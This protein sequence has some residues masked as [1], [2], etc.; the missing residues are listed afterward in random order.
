M[1]QCNIC[2]NRE[3][4]LIHAPRPEFV[5]REGQEYLKPMEL[6]FK[7]K[8]SR[9]E[10]QQDCKGYKPIVRQGATILERLIMSG[11]DQKAQVR[12]LL[13]AMRMKI[14]DVNYA[15]YFRV[16]PEHGSFKKGKA[17]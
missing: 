10:M 9:K 13:A 15:P 17:A 12:E 2:A 5:V 4:N 11:E 6:R 8:I 16:V 3:C 7:H 14:V 1:K